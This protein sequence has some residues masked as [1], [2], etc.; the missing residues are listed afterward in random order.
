MLIT[1]Y[2]VGKDSDGKSLCLVVKG[3]LPTECVPGRSE[4]V[5]KVNRQDLVQEFV[6]DGMPVDWVVFPDL[7]RDVIE[8]LESGA[9]LKI[10]DD[11]D[12]R[13]S[14]DC[15][16]SPPVDIENS[17]EPSCDTSR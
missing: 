16:L 17:K 3:V 15:K 4:L 12:E 11:A 9:G 8:L 1:E 10:I 6:Q 7:P 14:M 5:Q 2:L 13:M